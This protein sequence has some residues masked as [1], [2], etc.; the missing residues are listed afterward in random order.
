M[1]EP[2]LFLCSGVRPTAGARH[3]ERMVVRLDSIGPQANV[4]VRL[5]DVARALLRQLRPRLV[6][7]LEIAA[8]V[9]SADTATP[10]GT[11]WRDGQ[12]TEPWGRDLRF[13]I[14]VRDPAFWCEPDVIR[15]LVDALTFLADDRFSFEFV[16]LH[17]DR[18]T[19]GYLDFGTEWDDWPF[20]TADRV[21]MFSGGLDSLAGAVETASAGNNLVLVSHRSVHTINKRQRQLFHELRDTFP[22]VQ[23]IHVPVWVNK[24]SDLGKESTQRTR[25]FLFAALGT[26]IAE[27]IGA[28][29]VRFFENGVVSLNLPV[30]DEILRA[31]ASRTTHPQS[32]HLLT[33]LCKRVVGREFAIDKPLPLPD[34][35]GGGD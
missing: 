33:A 13:V 28:S 31:R 3:D 34:E 19:Q 29:G 11:Q 8:Y 17:E 27:S 15:L 24:E 9:F 18:P 22:A 21:L 35:D 16:P 10:R 4:N 1:I 7:F 14:P 26:V 2:R 6:D 25:S 5:E 23:M 20:A 12:S 30:A 32:L